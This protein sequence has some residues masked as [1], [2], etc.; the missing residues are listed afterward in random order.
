V[1][2]VKA[3]F[4][5]SVKPFVKRLLGVRDPSLRLVDCGVGK[6]LIQGDLSTYRKLGLQPVRLMTL[7][8]EELQCA[9]EADF[10]EHLRVFYLRPDGSL[11][12]SMKNTPHFKL[13]EYYREHG[14]E[15]LER[16]F[17]ELDYYRYFMCFNK[18]GHKTSFFD[19]TVKE[20][21]HFDDQRIWRKIGRFIDVYE[22]VRRY[23]YQ[24]GRFEGQLISVLKVPFVVSR[25]G[26]EVPY[27]PYEIFVGHHRATSLAVL[28][29][30]SAE[31]L[32]LEDARPLR[33]LAS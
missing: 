23:G 17:R 10:E 29:A 9:Y 13:L 3:A 30:R 24:A 4:M 20:P 7:P 32:L 33:R 8:L 22:N 21:V 14:R 27:K 19:P 31:V 28:G 26:M 11:D 18:V 25:F 12:R 2:I 15:A 6:P 16:H 5:K 1:Q